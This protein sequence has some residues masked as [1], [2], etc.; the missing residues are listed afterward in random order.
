MRALVVYESLFGNTRDVALAVAEGISQHMPVE[1]V[2]VGAAPADVDEDVTLL[3][4]GGPTHG[5]GLTTPSS[6]SDASRRAAG[7]VVSH[8]IGIREWVDG[9][10]PARDRLVATFDTRIKGPEFLW[11]SA[12]KAAAK[13]LRA[14]GF[15][16]V[17]EPHSFLLDGPTGPPFNRLRPGELEKARGWGAA[18]ATRA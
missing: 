3:V 10:R 15:T 18:L 12:A 7:D 14:T 11:G 4:V 1:A 16:R 5:H 6:R 8:G 9:L 17:E 13:R 2:E